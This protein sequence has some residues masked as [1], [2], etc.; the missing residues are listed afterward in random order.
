MNHF[1]DIGAN[2]GQTF[3]DFLLK[4]NEYDGWHVWC[5]EPSARHIPAL[6]ERTAALSD[7]FTIHVCAFGLSDQTG[8]FEFYE[9]I[10]PRGDSFEH[11]LAS[12]SNVTDNVD[13]KV[14][15]LSFCMNAAEFIE[16]YIPEGDRIWLKVD[17]EGSEYR[18]LTAILNRAGW[19]NDLSR[20]FLGAS[21]EWH[22]I[23]E[24]GDGVLGTADLCN[25]Y[26][27]RNL[28]LGTWGY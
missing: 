20:R 5:F 24:L 19:D 6:L 26:R 4:T 7:R 1:F 9:K 15:H 23:K 14:K 25:R 2:V 28:V 17:A 18:I 12:G 10:D 16:Q 22:R 8:P 21:V 27:E 11:Y 3:D 13:R